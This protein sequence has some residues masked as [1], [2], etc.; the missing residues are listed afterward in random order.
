MAF[1]NY[2]ASPFH[3]SSSPSFVSNLIYI[4]RPSASNSDDSSMAG[5]VSRPLL[6]SSRFNTSTTLGAL[7][8][9]ASFHSISQLSDSFTCT[10]SWTSYNFSTRDLN[11][12]AVIFSSLCIFFAA[13]N[14]LWTMALIAVI[15]FII[16]VGGGC[17]SWV[18]LNYPFLNILEDLFWHYRSSDPFYRLPN[19]LLCFEFLKQGHKLMSVFL[20]CPSHTRV[21]FNNPIR[22]CIPTMT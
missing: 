3:I 1:F 7:S 2:S 10:S 14:I 18:D 17:P 4:S 11:F 12:P 16:S 22:A 6:L 5:C 21:C 13:R 15:Y 19:W 8:T 9:L 20:V